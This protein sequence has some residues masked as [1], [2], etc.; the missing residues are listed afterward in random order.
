MEDEKSYDPGD[1]T[2]KFVN[3]QDDISKASLCLS[4]D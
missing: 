1:R 4:Y 3:R 2:L